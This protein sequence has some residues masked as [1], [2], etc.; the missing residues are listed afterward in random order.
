MEVTDQLHTLALFTPIKELTVPIQ[1]EAEWIPVNL[2]VLLPGDKTWSIQVH[3][4]FTTP[5]EL[6]RHVCLPL[7]IQLQLFV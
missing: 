2:E 5:T 6:S 3:S 4:P 7:K 1:Q